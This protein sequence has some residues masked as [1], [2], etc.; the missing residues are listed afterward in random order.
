M[1][2]LR[3]FDSVV[4]NHVRVSYSPNNDFVAHV[5]ES[6]VHVQRNNFLASQLLLG[7]H[8]SSTLSGGASATMTLTLPDTNVRISI[9]VGSYR[10]Y[11]Y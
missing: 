7:A 5:G 6:F 8:S 10:I 4:D 3:H 1:Q 2:V 9:F 11:W